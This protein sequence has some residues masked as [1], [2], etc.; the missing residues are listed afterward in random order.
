LEER[1]AT[2]REDN[3]LVPRTPG[4]LASHGPGSTALAELGYGF[5]SPRAFHE[6]VAR[7]AIGA[8]GG[9]LMV[10]LAYMSSGEV[11]LP[12][13]TTAIA[14][15]ALAAIAGKGKNWLRAAA[16]GALGILGGA[17][18]ALCTPAWPVFGALLLGLSAAPVLAKGES[19][20][21]MALT[22]VVTGMLSFLGLYVTGILQSRGVL[23]VMMPPPLA[24]AVAGSAAGL[25]FGLGAV[26]RHIVRAEDPLE[27]VFKAALEIKDGEIHEIL[28]R[29]HTI[30]QAVRG[31]LQ[32]R[33]VGP[34]EIELGQ[35]VSDLSHRI[36][37]IA[38]KCRSI[39]HDLGVAP[40]A[41]LESRIAVLARKADQATDP[42]ARSTFHSAIRSLDG[43]RRAVEAI[44]RG[45]E[46]VVARLHANVAL[47]EKVR[48]SL[49]HARS[50]DAERIGGEASPLT[51]AIE[52]LSRELDATSAAV[53]EVY[54]DQQDA[55][56]P[57]P[58]I[59]SGIV[60][61]AALPAVAS[62]EAAS[63]PAVPAPV[64]VPKSDTDPG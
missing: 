21:R 20:G 22:G 1:V 26:P 14:S 3:A 25:F 46:R 48:F 29:A 5:N 56:V 60:A 36:L 12:V 50:A 27:V 44:G 43:Q 47:L 13:L 34:T 10:G 49:V 16:G 63:P 35:R 11:S 32:A 41:E 19:P 51:E 15:G 9:S 62:P 37:Q 18:H 24:T 39:E 40:A 31:D 54:S 55:L 53:G 64:A 45:L 4:A 33:K 2:D 23:A 42:L 7:A 52:E 30:H 58:E 57:V 6:T 59:P 28:T 61:A 17:L 8:A 38:E